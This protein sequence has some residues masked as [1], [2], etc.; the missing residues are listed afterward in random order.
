MIADDDLSG[1]LN[2]PGLSQGRPR[3]APQR[4]AVQPAP[5]RPSKVAPASAND[6]ISGTV[7]P[8]RSTGITPRRA[9]ASVPTDPTE[10]LREIVRNTRRAA[11]ALK[12]SP[13]ARPAISVGMLLAA[14]PPI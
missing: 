4:S 2:F 3:T 13:Q 14:A 11:D 7:L 8:K 5:Q 10:C 12:R 6:V 9:E 1:L